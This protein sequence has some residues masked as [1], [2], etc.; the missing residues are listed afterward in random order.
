MDIRQ[1]REKDLRVQA[2]HVS[3]LCEQKI[4]KGKPIW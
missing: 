3:Y 2:S 1:L 4:A